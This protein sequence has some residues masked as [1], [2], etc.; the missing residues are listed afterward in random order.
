MSTRIIVSNKLQDASLRCLW[1][2]NRVLFYFTVLL[3]SDVCFT[4]NAGPWKGFPCFIEYCWMCIFSKTFKTANLKYD[5]DGV[6]LGADDGGHKHS[7]NTSSSLT[8][9]LL[10]CVG[11]SAR[12]WPWIVSRSAACGFQ[13][14][15]LI[16]PCKT[17]RALTLLW[18]W[19][20]IFQ[21]VAAL[22][23]QGP[24]RGRWPHKTA[25]HSCQLAM[26]TEH[27]QEINLC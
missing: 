1:A 6:H 25:P 13:P 26:D 24:E 11:P 8:S 21:T 15:H 12:I 10:H 5:L 14:G 7:P 4:L 2:V 18:G 22:P 23:A 16:K 3:N 17:L 19:R 9:V 27:E 20:A